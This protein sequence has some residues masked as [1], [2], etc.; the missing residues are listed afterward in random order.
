MSVTVCSDIIDLD[1]LIPRGVDNDREDLDVASLIPWIFQQTGIEIVEDDCTMEWPQEEMNFR[2]LFFWLS[3]YYY[4]VYEREGIGSSLEREDFRFFIRTQGWMKNMLMHTIYHNLDGIREERPRIIF[5]PQ[6]KQKYIIGGKRFTF[7]SE[8][9][10]TVR[11]QEGL[12]PIISY[13]GCFE[14]MTWDQFLMETL[15]TMLGQFAKT[16]SIQNGN[17]GFQGQ[18]VYV[19]G[20]Y[21]RYIHVACGLFP[22]DTIAR[23]HSQGCSK[24]EVFDLKF[25]RGYDLYLLGGNTKASAVQAYLQRAI[26]TVNNVP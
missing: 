21:G 17:T 5:E 25:T 23:V 26:T 13:T 16:T 7:K 22:A 18:E 10:A 14:G 6:L 19:V 20:L 1:E 12:V 15:S 11:L 9:A 3:S 2:D 4:E 8:G 24:D